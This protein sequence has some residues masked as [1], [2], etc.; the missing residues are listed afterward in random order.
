[1][2][3][4]LLSANANVNV[5]DSH[6]RTLL[7]HASSEG[8]V[9]IVKL[10]LYVPGTHIE[11]KCLSYN[12]G[13]KT[14]DMTALL[15]AASKGQ[16]DIVELLLQEVADIDAKD[17]WKDA[18]NNTPLSLAARGEEAI[19]KLLLN[20]RRVNVDTKNEYG[21]TPLFQAIAYG[22]ERIFDI[23]LQGGADI[24]AS[25]DGFTV[26]MTACTESVRIL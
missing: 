8:H 13:R 23:L 3:E 16:D 22:Q 6:G 15:V 4:Q 11:H 20:T 24:Q 7:F 10:L 14:R 26:L 18:W 5:E 17:A 19:V 21:Q 9:A 2:V 1:M 12:M 25:L